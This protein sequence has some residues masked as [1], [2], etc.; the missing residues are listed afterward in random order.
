MELL[1]QRKNRRSVLLVL[2]RFYLPPFN[3]CFSLHKTAK[4]CCST[5][6]SGENINTATKTTE[7]NNS[8]FSLYVDLTVND[9]TQPLN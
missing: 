7:F 8:F 3:K 5:G 2:V 4:I 1:K 9:G 6:F